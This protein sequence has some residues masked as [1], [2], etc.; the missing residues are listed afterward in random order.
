M[1][2]SIMDRERNIDITEDLEVRSVLK[3]TKKK[4]LGWWELV[5]RMNEDRPVKR[6]GRFT[7]TVHI[8]RIGQAGIISGIG[9]FSPGLWY[10]FFTNSR[11]VEL[12]FRTDGKCKNRHV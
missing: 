1:E 2:V 8:H 9:A 12:T 5:E 11:I 6:I 4:Q 7:R 3:H 10:I